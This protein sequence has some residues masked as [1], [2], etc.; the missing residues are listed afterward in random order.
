MTLGTKRA[1]FGI[2]AQMLMIFA[3][4]PA[5]ASVATEA[6][7]STGIAGSA[8][9]YTGGRY[10]VAFARLALDGQTAFGHFAIDG[11]LLGDLPLAGNSTLGSAIAGLRAGV[12]F[13]F[14]SALLGVTMNVQGAGLQ[15]LPSLT[16]RVGGD[17]RGVLG[18]FD[19]DGLAPIRIGVEYKDFG[20]SFLA[21]Y[22]LELH[23]RYPITPAFAIRG[24]LL[25][26]QLFGYGTF[27]ALA[28]VVWSPQ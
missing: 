5:R 19:L 6:S 2:A 28:G 7:A 27:S 1:L 20:A 17:L 24:Q 25:A 21:I 13:P 22:G 8:I 12:S 3:I 14:V 15:T 18:L 10:G 9:S 26:Y 23:G 11:W 16:L 4:S